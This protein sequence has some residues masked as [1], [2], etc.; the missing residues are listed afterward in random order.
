MAVM[1]RAVKIPAGNNSLPAI[2]AQNYTLDSAGFCVVSSV[3]MQ[4]ADRIH[5]GKT[6]VAHGNGKGQLQLF[7]L[8]FCLCQ[9]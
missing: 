6:P 4:I 5:A 7:C 9:R 8:F 1:T 3:A 2:R